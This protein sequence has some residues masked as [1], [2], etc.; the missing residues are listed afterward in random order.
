MRVVVDAN[1]I[2]AAL[3]QP[4]GWTGQQL[5]RTDADW[6][7]PTALAAELEAHS[8]E[9]AEKAGC[10]VA[11]WRS[12]LR[13][14]LSRIAI[15]PTSECAGAVGDPLF[16]RAMQLD[17]DDAAYVAVLIVSGAQLFW[18]RDKV[19]LAAFPSFAVSKVPGLE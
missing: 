10:Y 4:D 12:R 15:V 16:E 8:G 9:Y 5:R 18:T 19:M 7:A 14:V 3:I 11:E 6:V 2:A 13:R 1:V 17:P